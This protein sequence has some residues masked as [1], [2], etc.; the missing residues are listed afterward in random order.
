MIAF[1]SRAEKYRLPASSKIMPSVTGASPMSSTAAAIVDSGASN[2]R[3]PHGHA[4]QPVVADR[5]VVDPLAVRADRDPVAVDDQRLAGLPQQPR[6]TV[7]DR[8]LLG[9]ALGR[10]VIG[11]HSPDVVRRRRRSR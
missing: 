3:A 11:E 10:V 1:S 4:V 9:E 7:D 6:R 5:L 8:R 2:R